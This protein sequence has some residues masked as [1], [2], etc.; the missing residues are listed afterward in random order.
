MACRTQS[1]ES[2]LGTQYSFMIS[3]EN[4]LAPAKLIASKATSALACVANSTTAWWTEEPSVSPALT[5]MSNLY[6]GLLPHLAKEYSFREAKKSSGLGQGS[7]DLA[8]TSM[9]EVN[10]QVSLKR[11]SASASTKPET[12]RW[13]IP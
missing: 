7:S 3:R 5:V 9:V 4:R 6:I 12:D 11:R 2:G 8:R 13:K 1:R 10:P